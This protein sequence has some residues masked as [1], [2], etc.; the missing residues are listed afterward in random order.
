[1]EEAGGFPELDEFCAQNG[2]RF[3]LLAARLASM[4][5]LQ[6]VQVSAAEKQSPEERG[7]LGW[8]EG[9]AAPRSA[10]EVGEE[11]QDPSVAPRG[12]P[13]KAGLAHSHNRPL[14]P[15]SKAEADISNL[16]NVL[17][18]GEP[19][20]D[21]RMVAFA[22]HMRLKATKALEAYVYLGSC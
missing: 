14:T 8:S 10:P 19:P 9:S 15:P 20:R 11:G 2:E 22:G 16:A 6:A 4:S 3:P 21:L 12:N 1:M 18:F 7:A 13:L 5:V 17:P